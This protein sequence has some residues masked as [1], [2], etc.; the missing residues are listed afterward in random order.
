MQTEEE[1]R[2][3]EEEEADEHGGH[4]A[5]SRPRQPHAATRGNA[6][7][8]YKLRFTLPKAEPEKMTAEL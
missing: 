3:D 8:I 7:A 6:S 2:E 5:V 4:T 1:E